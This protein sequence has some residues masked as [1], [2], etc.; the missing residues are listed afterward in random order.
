MDFQY[1][2][3]CRDKSYCIIYKRSILFDDNCEELQIG[4]EIEFLWP[5]DSGKA[6]PYRG[7][8][9]KISG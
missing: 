1:L 3:H 9:V 4:A 2:V 6:K 8:I 7:K 5:E